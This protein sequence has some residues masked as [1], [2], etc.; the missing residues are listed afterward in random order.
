MKQCNLKQAREDSGRPAREIADTLGLSR[1]QLYRI[2]SGECQASF[3]V[4]RKMRELWPKSKVPDLAIYDPEEY[5][6][7]KV[8]A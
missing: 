4:A 3:T 6:N 5:E 1:S 8:A 2:E 7:R